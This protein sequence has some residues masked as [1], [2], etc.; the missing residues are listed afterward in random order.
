MFVSEL[1][2]QLGRR[3]YIGG[4]TPVRVEVAGRVYGIDPSAEVHH[5]Q[6][7]DGDDMGLI[8]VIPA[9][10]R[11][12]DPIDMVLPCPQCGT[13]HVDAPE[14]EKGW[15]NPPH[16]SHL[17]H[18]CGC[19]WRPA[20]VPTNGVYRVGTRGEKDTFPATPSHLEGGAG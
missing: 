13:I 20:D 14:P 7:Q 12:L 16:R 6:D 1:I 17:C 15:K 4:D 2:Q 10:A 3:I 5:G 11:E 9:N 18:K 19:I 8:A